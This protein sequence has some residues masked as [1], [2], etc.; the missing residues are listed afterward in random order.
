[1]PSSINSKDVSLGMQLSG[2]SAGIDRPLAAV[3]LCAVY[4][5][6]RAL[7]IR[8]CSIVFRRLV[9]PSRRRIQDLYPR[10]SVTI[11]R[12]HSERAAIVRQ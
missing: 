6:L 3:E 7:A 5:G 8:L 11:H 4:V 2:C 1:M 10:D 9:R 12:I